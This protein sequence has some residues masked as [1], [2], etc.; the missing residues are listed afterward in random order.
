VHEQLKDRLDIGPDIKHNDFVPLLAGDT[1][2]RESVELVTPESEMDDIFAAFE[3][4]FGGEDFEEQAY[5]VFNGLLTFDSA[6]DADDAPRRTVQDIKNDIQSFMANPEIIQMQS[7]MDRIAI[8]AAAFCQHNG[9]S[10]DDIGLESESKS[11]ES[12]NKKDKEDEKDG[13]EANCNRKRDGKC[14]CKLK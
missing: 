6:S 3:T 12:D 8:Q 14:S 13:H 5:E 1:V 11:E 9:I 4:E 7:L 2:L 10:S